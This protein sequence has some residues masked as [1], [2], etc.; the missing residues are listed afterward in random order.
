MV[1]HLLEILAIEAHLTIKKR[2]KQSQL[3]CK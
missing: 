2:I 1:Y 3:T